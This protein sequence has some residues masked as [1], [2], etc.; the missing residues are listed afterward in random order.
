MKAMIFAAGKGT[1]L[2]ALGLKKPKALVE[3]NGKAL[4]LRSLETAH[5]LGITEVVVNIHH[6][7]EQIIEFLGQHTPPSL[8]IHLSDERDEL[9]DTGGGL[10]KAS[11][12]LGGTEDILLM[13]ADIIHSIDL[14]K[15]HA[16]H[17]QSGAL[18]TLAVSKRNS[19]RQLLFDQQLLLRGWRE[20]KPG[21]AKEEQAYQAYAFSGVHLIKPELFTLF[22][23]ETIF[24]IIPFYLK[25][26]QQ[27]PIRAFEHSAEG[28]FD[29]GT[30]EKIARAEAFLQKM[31]P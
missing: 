22:D 15:M 2:G 8:N 14:R 9:L 28:W 24:P 4:L 10:K 5:S 19:S 20:N 29:L 18:A 26:C 3:I 11:Q 1:R 17:Q 16:Q 12:F 6:L 25:W 27:Y 23:Q 13:N 21:E 31:N 7:G 30:P